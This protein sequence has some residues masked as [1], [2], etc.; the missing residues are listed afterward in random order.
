MV[1]LFIMRLL[2]SEWGRPIGGG[3][4]GCRTCAPGDSLSRGSG[5]RP[6]AR[7]VAGDL[8]DGQPARSTLIVIAFRGRSGQRKASPRTGMAFA[9]GALVAQRVVAVPAVLRRMSRRRPGTV[10]EYSHLRRHRDAH[11]HL[12]E[13][14]AST[15]G[16]LRRRT[17]PGR[18]RAAD[19]CVG[20]SGRSRMAAT[21][22]P[23][24]MAEARPDAC[25]RSGARRHL[26]L[27]LCRPVVVR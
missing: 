16:G 4:A 8:H 24:S 10:A 15:G 22:T 25:I 21:F 12:A 27:G 17:H 3:N 2:V 14:T 7:K 9:S 6:S 11:V 1:H 20:S 18:A 23:V 5:P 26:R 13:T 19:G